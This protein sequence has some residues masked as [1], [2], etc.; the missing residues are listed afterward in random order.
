M[1]F[2]E[3]LNAYL[4]QLQCTASELAEA[5]GLTSASVSRYR[6][7]QRNP[8]ADTLK[9]LCAGIAKIALQK[10]KTDITYESVTLSLTENQK[11][12][13]INAVQFS[14]QFSDLIT[15]FGINLNELAKM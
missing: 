12:I 9:K 3:Q 7:G 8:D 2:S 4:K 11:F 1:T 6:S 5:S 15:T 10:G 14:K 13:E